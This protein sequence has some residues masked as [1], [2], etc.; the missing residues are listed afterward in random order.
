V[1][2]K[3]GVSIRSSKSFHSKARVSFQGFQ[4]LGFLLQGFK[5]WNPARVSIQAKARVS[6]ARV[7]ISKARVSVSKA[8]G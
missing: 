7:S 4:R 3:A 6:K 8:K 5:G 1:F 2:S